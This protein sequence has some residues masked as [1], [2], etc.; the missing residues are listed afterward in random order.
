M[1][2]KTFDTLISIVVGLLAFNTILAAYVVY[3][4]IAE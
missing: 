3:K 1:K 4:L 2:D